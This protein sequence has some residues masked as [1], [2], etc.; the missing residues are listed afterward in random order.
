M[1]TTSRQL[2]R[3]IVVA[4]LV[5]VVWLLAESRP[6]LPLTTGLTNAN[7]ADLLLTFLAWLGCLLLAL[8]LLYRT[9]ARSHRGGAVGA[10]PIRHLERLRR[11]PRHRET[12]RGYSD[13]A[14]PLIL[15]QPPPLPAE[16]APELKPTRSD[17]P[18]TPDISRPATPPAALISVL[19]PLTITGT[20]Q[21]HGRH[22]RGATRELL[23]Y[24]ALHPNGAHRDQIIDALWP[25]QSPEHG[26]KRLW[27]AATDARNQLG[28]TAVSRDNDRYQL[29]RN[30]ISVDLDQLEQLLTE[31][32][33]NDGAKHQL[34]KLEQA[35]A[36]FKGEPLT[37]SDLPWAAN[38]Q[39]HLHAIQLEL[40]E[41]I[42]QAHLSNGNASRA[43]ARAQDG[44]A[45]E[46]YNEKLA[47]LAMQAEAALG[48]R[49]A[50]ISRYDNLRH[51]LDQQLGLQPH[52]ETRTLYRQLLS[53]DEQPER[54]PPAVTTP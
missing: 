46:P 31:L 54:S 6:P 36:L 32:G 42:A 8:G 24:L 16:S 34:S 50:V 44:L 40:L 38:E 28:D 48:L 30:Q 23:A 11:E 21:K 20:R 7:G 53:Q 4:V 5:G 41:R 49:S 45:H 52:R 26:R 10:V 1:R 35:L 9:R 22:L 51:L 15:K 17:L 29:D 14:F 27:R 25:D 47:R 18:N 13:R 19:G 43:L 2:L 37:G 3:P 39:R 12:A 33:Q